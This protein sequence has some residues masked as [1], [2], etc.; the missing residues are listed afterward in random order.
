M[1]GWRIKCLWGW[2]NRYSAWFGSVER[3]IGGVASL[4]LPGGLAVAGL[5]AVQC[6]GSIEQLIEPA[7]TCALVMHAILVNVALGVLFAVL[8]LVFGPLLYRAMG[9]EG[10]SLRAAF[11]YSDV[12]FT[13]AVLVWV[14]NALASVVRGTGNMLVPSLAVWAASF[15]WFRCHRC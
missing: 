1:Q 11:D 9:G 15:C 8:F 12:V 5:D 2:V 13:G 14:M 3:G 7:L 10:A 6:R 4:E